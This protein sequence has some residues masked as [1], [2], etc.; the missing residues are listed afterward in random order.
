MQELPL[1]SARTNLPGAPFLA[2]LT[3]RP[4]EP[5][6]PFCSFA[7]AYLPAFARCCLCDGRCAG[8][9]VQ[10]ACAQRLSTQDRVVVTPHPT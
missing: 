7:A 8:P 9:W 10:A 1:R 6:L 5:A 4:R 2:A 3:Q